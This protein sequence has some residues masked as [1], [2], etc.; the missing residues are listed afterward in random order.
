MGAKSET[1]QDG[2]EMTKRHYIVS[3]N[4]KKLD[5]KPLVGTK[6]AV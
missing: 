6:V 1:V 3:Y 4:L 5:Q 2:L